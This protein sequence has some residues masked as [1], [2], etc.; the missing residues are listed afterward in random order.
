MFNLVWMFRDTV[1]CV[2]YIFI[3]KASTKLILNSN[4][5]FRQIVCNVSHISGVPGDEVL[6]VGLVLIC[7]AYMPSSP[8]KPSKTLRSATFVCGGSR[9]VP[10]GL[11]YQ[12]ES[13][14]DMTRWVSKYIWISFALLPIS[15]TPFEGCVLTET[16]R[17]CNPDSWLLLAGLNRLIRGNRSLMTTFG[18]WSSRNHVH[19]LILYYRP[20]KATKIKKCFSPYEIGA[21]C[22]IWDGS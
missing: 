4:A 1:K 14:A 19:L 2:V 18:V 15:M 6:I 13:L 17:A 11:S 8:L 5:R 21:L 22:D 20:W 16:S 10:L 9:P 7:T 12:R 3:N